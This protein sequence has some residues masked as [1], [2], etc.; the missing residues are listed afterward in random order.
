VLAGLVVYPFDQAHAVFEGYR[1]FT[2]DAPQEMT[3]WLVLR[4]APPL[5]FLPPAMHGKEVVIVAFCWIGEI[6]RGNELAARLRS[7][8]K[9]AGEQIGPMPFAA[10]QTAFDPLLAPVRRN[11]WKSHD[12]KALSGDVERIVCD[13]ILRLPSGECEAFIGHL[14]GAINR[15]PASETAYPHRDVEFVLNVHTRWREPRDDARCIGWARG[16][17]DA[18]TPHA[19]GGVYVNF[20]PEDETQRVA[21]GA[22]G[23]N[24]R[25]TRAAEGELRPRQPVLPQPEHP[26]AGERIGPIRGPGRRLS[27]VPPVAASSAFSISAVTLATH[28]MARRAALLRGARVR[29]ALWRRDGIV[30]QPR[31]R[32]CLPEPDRR[33][34]GRANLVLV[35]A[36][37]LP[38]R[39]CRRPS[40]AG[41]RS[42]PAAR[43]RTGRRDLGRTLLPHHRPRRPR[44]ELR[45]AAGVVEPGRHRVHRRP[46]RPERPVP[47]R[48]TT[49]R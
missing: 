26:A 40:R 5:P 13:A 46:R 15:V 8:G 43:R 7:F 24:L 42:R 45:D 28:D 41:R 23:P 19:T 36:H 22:Y 4:Q 3:A 12:F 27:R 37:H 20:M 21:A 9:P 2:A 1:R 25:T 32:Q 6:E 38:R 16:L 34:D 35:G 17:F 31:C 49:R 29:I 30:Q 33:G 48:R 14:G 18:L 10:W 11:Y 44:A 39:R 47:A